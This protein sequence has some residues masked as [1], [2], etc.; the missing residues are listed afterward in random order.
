MKLRHSIDIIDRRLEHPANDNASESLR[1]M[2]NDEK[3][4]LT[5]KMRRE[6]LM[7]PIPGDGVTME[8]LRNFLTKRTDLHGLPLTMGKECYSDTNEISD[9]GQVSFLLG[10]MIGQFNGSPGSRNVAQNDAFR[11]LSIKQA[12]AFFTKNPSSQK[13]RTIDQIIQIDHPRLR[14]EFIDKLQKSGSDAAIELIANKAKFDLEPEVRSAA[15]DA[16][17]D[18][19][20]EKYRAHLFEG[21]KYPWHV[22]AEHS[23]EAFVRLND[24]DSIP[25]LIEMLDLPH[26][27]FPTKINGQFGQRELV[28]INHMRNCLMCHAPSMSSM[29]STRGLIPHTSRPLPQHYYDVTAGA[30]P[31]PFS[32]RAD[33][34]YLE[35]DFSVMQ[36]VEDSGPWP[37]TQRFDYVVQ[38]RKLTDAEATKE[39]ERIWQMPNRNRNAIIYALRELTGEAPED[40]S[41]QNWRSITDRDNGRN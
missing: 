23:A 37:R 22:V 29:D 16:L 9:L 11:N 27:Q 28:S 31:I 14:L 2:L 33:I 8:P 18:I 38:N 30:D 25:K 34:T 10:R 41:S 39:A 40:N 19:A 26:P 15:T 36:R 32:V 7:R 17:S 13:L 5:A 1:T 21:L 4:S 20:P 24:Q 12:I 35:Q 6:V 3:G